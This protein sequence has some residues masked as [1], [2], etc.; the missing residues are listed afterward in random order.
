M[1]SW[2]LII[3]QAHKAS[4]L[5]IPW[6]KIININQTPIY[7]EQIYIYMYEYIYNIMNI[8]IECKYI[9][10]ATQLTRVYSSI[11]NLII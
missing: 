3:T 8:Q 7:I 10:L 2:T 11:F 5:I 6:L 1:Y 4:E 9:N